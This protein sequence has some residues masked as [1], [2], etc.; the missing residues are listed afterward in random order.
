MTEVDEWA[1]CRSEPERNLAEDGTLKPIDTFKRYEDEYNSDTEDELDVAYQD[2]DLFLQA[3]GEP[4]LVD[5]FVRHR[6]TLGQLLEFS[7]QDLIDC[8]IEFVG[9]RKK[10]LQNTGQMHS[11]K[12][13]P[14]SLHDLSAKNLL[15]SPGLYI[16][17]NDINKHMEYI[18]ITFKYL[19]K[20]LE[21]RPE[22]LELGKDYVGVAKVSSEIE[23][24]LKTCKTTYS[25][26]RTLNR[27]VSKHLDDPAKRPANHI[28]KK[29]ILR[30]KLRRR[31]IPG[32]MA[33]V[34][35]LGALK[36]SMFLLQRK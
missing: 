19:K 33:G 15:S 22:I 27:E 28:D 1:A 12:W 17:L 5:H 18:G 13:M 11:E 23:D 24:L 20:R 31:L 14:S 9:D 35:L 8:G 2:L 10:I 4:Q 3:I 16:A 36:L 32:V 21:E 26:L 34:V 6:V 29:Y 25:Q 30:A 7:E